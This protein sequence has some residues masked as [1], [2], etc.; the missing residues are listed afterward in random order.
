MAR[1]FRIMRSTLY[2]IIPETC[3]A[4]YES[5]SAIYLRFPEGE[6]WLAIAQEFQQ[7]HN[8]PHCLGA[9]DTKQVTIEKPPHSGSFF[10]DYKEKFTIGFMGTS[11]AHKR[12]IWALVGS[13]GGLL[14][15]LFFF[16]F[17]KHY[18]FCFYSLKD[19]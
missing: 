8:F 19:P 14:L 15:N 13:Y 3:T 9:I 6:D 7:I 11:D 17:S 5:L 10:Y 16:Y 12:F 18:I 4:I 1:V 2:G